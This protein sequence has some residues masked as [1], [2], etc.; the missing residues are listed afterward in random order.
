MSA[1]RY[2]TIGADSFVSQ[3]STGIM[4]A[5]TIAIASQ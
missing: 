1:S 4:N 5:N 2:M 3:P